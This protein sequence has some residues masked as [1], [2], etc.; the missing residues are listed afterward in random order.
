MTNAVLMAQLI[1]LRRLKRVYF[2]KRAIGYY[3]GDTVWT[4]RVR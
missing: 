1:A 4:V 3:T 2:G